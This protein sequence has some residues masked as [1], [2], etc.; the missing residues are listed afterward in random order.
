MPEVSVVIDAGAF[1]QLRGH[2]FPG[3]GDEHG[4]VLTAGVAVGTRGTRLLVR[5]VFLAR[6]G[7]DYI[8]GQR[9]YRA[10][11]P[12]FVAEKA[13]YCRSQNLAYLAVHCHGGTSEVGFSK[14]DLESHERGY[15]A[16]LDITRGGPVGALVFADAAVAG[17]IWFPDGRIELAHIKIVGPT[18]Q[19]LYSG[20]RHAP[21]NA[22]PMYDRHVRLFGDIGQ[23]RL[24]A[25][26]VGIIGLGGGGSL[27]NEWLSRLGVGRIVAVDPERI[28]QTNL[29][30]V[31][32]ASRLD[33]LWWMSNSKSGLMQ[34]IAGRFAKHK[35]YIARRVARQANPEVDF[36]AVVGDVL[37]EDVAGLLTDVDFLL[38]A[39]DNIASRLVFNAIV[40]QYLIPGYQVGVKVLKSPGTSE[41]GEITVINRPVLPQS[42]G[43]CLKC[44]GAIPAGRVQ[45]EALTNA[46]R[47]RQRYIDDVAV[48]QPS[49]ITL[50][51]L[52]AAQAANDL[53][54][55]V[56][57]LLNDNVKLEQRITYPR[58][59]SEMRVSARIASDCLDC[60]SDRKSRKG[61]GDRVRLPCRQRSERRTRR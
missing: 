15:P 22:Q 25:L 55:A 11:T 17:D 21:Q 30:R 10:L 2:L 48:A 50:N 37:D 34:S 18:I 53:L 43:G 7:T 47:K 19:H 26:K 8:P 6:D 20:P 49:V 61:R 31:V 56:N 3:D 42:G 54:F 44:Q 36:D 9:G 59:R 52:S 46:E 14:T 12:R 32:G 33:A 57:G 40:H 27:L 5:E 23:S 58:E 24:R 28:D 60:G 16:L 39:T 1:A 29:P 38:L 13:E 35:V 45:S 51:V 4:A 41:V